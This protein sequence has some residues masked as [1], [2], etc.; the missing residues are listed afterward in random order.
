MCLAGC[1]RWNGAL[2]ARFRCCFPTR[3]GATHSSRARRRTVIGAVVWGVSSVCVEEAIEQALRRLTPSRLPTGDALR[4]EQL[5]LDGACVDLPFAE[6]LGPE[7]HEHEGTSNETAPGR[8]QTSQDAAGPLGAVV[9]RYLRKSNVAALESCR[10]LRGSVGGGKGEGGG[11]G[12]G[13]EG[14]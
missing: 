10:E 4:C 8:L 3:T 9:A 12:G 13:G 11:K 14:G 6:H 5:L 7:S 2:T 1:R